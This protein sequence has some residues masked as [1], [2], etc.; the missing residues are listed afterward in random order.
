MKCY[1]CRQ[2]LCFSEDWKSERLSWTQT[3]LS[4]PSLFIISPASMPSGKNLSKEKCFHIGSC[5]LL[6]ALCFFIK[7]LPF[8]LNT[9]ASRL[10]LSYTSFSVLSRRKS[11]LKNRRAPSRSKP[12]TFR[13]QIIF[14][15]L[16]MVWFQSSRSVFQASH[17][18]QEKFSWNG[19]SFACKGKTWWKK[20]T[21]KSIK[22]KGKVTAGVPGVWDTSPIDWFSLNWL[23]K[24]GML[25]LLCCRGRDSILNYLIGGRVF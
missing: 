12:M 13:L 11:E 18:N 5:F 4:L 17:R 9:V 23:Q 25:T 7:L 20:K 2:P 22:I 8:I 6:T 15:L 14:W 19:P 21:K 10:S 24:N 1:T 3:I 16:P